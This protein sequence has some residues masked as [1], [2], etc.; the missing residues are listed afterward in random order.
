MWRETQC[1]H[2]VMCE[3]LAVCCDHIPEVRPE[4]SPAWLCGWLDTDNAQQI[5]SQQSG[6]RGE[7]DY[8]YTTILITI[9]PGC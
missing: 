8:I 2:S 1:D 4:T 7:K 9:I 3:L 6:W 5:S